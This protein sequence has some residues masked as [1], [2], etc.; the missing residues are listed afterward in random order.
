MVA[1]TSAKCRPG[2]ESGYELRRSPLGAAS[3]GLHGR[4]HGRCLTYRGCSSG[5]L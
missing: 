3:P 1:G 5:T 2:V 4:I